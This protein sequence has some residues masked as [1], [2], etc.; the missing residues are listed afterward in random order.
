MTTEFTII[1][2]NLIMKSSLMNIHNFAGCN[3]IFTLT[4]GKHVYFINVL[5]K[6][7]CLDIIATIMI[8][9]FY[10]VFPKGPGKDWFLLPETG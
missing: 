7:I 8:F 4:T 1:L 2:F 3:L 5:Y 9:T 6:L 10:Y